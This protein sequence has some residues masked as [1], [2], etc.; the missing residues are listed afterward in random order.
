MKVGSFSGMSPLFVFLLNTCK[1]IGPGK[2]VISQAVELFVRHGKSVGYGLLR[3]SQSCSTLML[4]L[5]LP[6]SF[7][8]TLSLLGGLDV[9]D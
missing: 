9:K 3:L 1:L 4:V 2:N 5:T 6:V 8:C 7:H